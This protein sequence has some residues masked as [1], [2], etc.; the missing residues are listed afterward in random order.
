MWE[1][2]GRLATLFAII[3]ALWAVYKRFINPKRRRTKLLKFT[4]MVTEWIDEID[5]NLDVGLNLA[6]INNKE[7][8]I[9]EFIKDNLPTYWIRPSK[10]MIRKWNKEMGIKKE[11]WDSQ[12]KFEEYSRVSSEGIPLEFFFNMLV[13]KFQSFT[14][15]YSLK[16]N[17]ECN[18]ADI[19]MPAK[20][21]RFY[22][23]E[24]Y[25]I[26]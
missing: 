6:A 10:K 12:D 26:D 11:L 9:R 5:C 18:F 17:G 23:K 1:W 8:K 24:K 16:Q 4:K 25:H 15:Y 7:N 21:L 14:A 19:E 2:F 3:G 13:C 22:L 20:F